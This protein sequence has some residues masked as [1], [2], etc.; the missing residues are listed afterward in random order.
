MS[1]SQTPLLHKVIPL[2]DI[3][4]GHLDKFANNTDNFPAVQAAAQQGR[5]MMNKYYGLTDEQSC[6]ELPCVSGSVFICEIYKLISLGSTSSMLQ[7]NVF[8]E[9][10][11][12]RLLDYNYREDTEGRMDKALQEVCGTSPC[13]NDGMLLF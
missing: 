4:T 5:T 13:R 9:G 12:A 3:L 10:K 1:Q 7:V 11:M 2:F 8:H 6:I